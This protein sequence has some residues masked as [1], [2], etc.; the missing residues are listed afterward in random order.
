[1]EQPILLPAGHYFSFQKPS[2]EKPLKI[3]VAD[4]DLYI[5]LF[6]APFIPFGPGTGRSIRRLDSLLDIEKSNMGCSPSRF[7]GVRSSKTSAS[8][9][10][11]SVPQFP[12]FKLLA[13]ERVHNDIRLETRG[14]PHPSQTAAYSSATNRGGPFMK[15]PP[16]WE[17]Y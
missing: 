15:S 11:T 5:S 4:L 8:A 3:G 17:L 6:V 2:S 12:H 14:Y 10:L 16:S 7:A 1:M 13:N 9:N